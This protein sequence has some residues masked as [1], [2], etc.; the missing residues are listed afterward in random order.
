MVSRRGGGVR[1]RA[2]SRST[3]QRPGAPEGSAS[4]KGA[5]GGWEAES[6]SEASAEACGTPSSPG[7]HERAPGRLLG[8]GLADRTGTDTSDAMETDGDSFRDDET[9]GGYSGGGASA[10][11]E[12]DGSDGGSFGAA[13]ED[14]AQSA[15][16]E[17][18][19][20]QSADAESD[21]DAMSEAAGD[22]GEE[23]DEAGGGN[24]GGVRASE[25]GGSRAPGEGRT[26]PFRTGA[27]PGAGGDTREGDR[28]LSDAL[29]VLTAGECSVNAVPDNLGTGEIPGLMSN[30][31]P[32]GAGAGLR[33][34]AVRL[35]LAGVT[36][37][38][39][40]VVLDGAWAAA[41]EAREEGERKR[42]EALAVTKAAADAKAREEA[43]RRRAELGEVRV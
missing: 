37:P 20:G 27:A 40:A 3:G 26:A 30:A 38:G 17:G 19:D 5:A 23:G 33:W 16:S 14:D 9:D 6:A 22:E 25:R 13:E 36:K 42:A 18:C 24:P 8:G 41:E 39:E 2:P 7:D 29:S 31:T 43:E 4:A 1:A 21:A 35:R 28:T 34:S 10:D 15:M 11:G 32:T 12:E